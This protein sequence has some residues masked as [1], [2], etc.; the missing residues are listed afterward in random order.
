MICLFVFVFTIS[1]YG[2]A[3]GLEIKAGANFAP[4]TGGNIPDI[5]GLTGYY[6]GSYYQMPVIND[7]LYFQP[8]LQY[9]AQGFC[10]SCFRN[11][12]RLYYGLFCS[13]HVSKLYVLKFLVL[14]QDHNLDLR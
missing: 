13:S 5:G 8:E 1:N 3:Q 7:L 4:V 9:S 11:N 2:A 10:S 6:A 14:R 12:S